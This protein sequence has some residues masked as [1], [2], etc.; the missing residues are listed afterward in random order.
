M[1]A[2]FS[3]YTESEFVDLLKRIVSSEGSE[4]EVDALVFHFEKIS[5]H[6][7]GSDLIFYPDDGEDDSPEGIT[8]TV[9][10]WR[11]SKGL[12]GFKQ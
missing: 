3:D 7:S 2:N 8:G 11:A 12:P 9:K 6:P 4:K 10:K 5:E 1:K